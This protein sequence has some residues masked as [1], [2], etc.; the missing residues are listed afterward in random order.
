MRTF[1][2][3]SGGPLLLEEKHGKFIQIGIVSWGAGEKDGK[4]A[5]AFT[6]VSGSFRPWFLAHAP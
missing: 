6:R 5:S 4:V 3:D 2:S 1:Q